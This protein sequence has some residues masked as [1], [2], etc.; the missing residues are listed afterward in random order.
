MN[1]VQA[2]AALACRPR[3]APRTALA[4]ALLLGLGSSQAALQGRD[5]DGIAATFEAYYDTALGITWLADGNYAN[6]QFVASGGIQGHADGLMDWAA[7]KSWADGLDVHGITGWRLPTVRPINGIAFNTLIISNNGIT[8]VGTAKT[9]VGWGTASELGH[10]FY[11]S[12]ANLGLCT[13]ND[14]QP[15]QCNHQIGHTPVQNSGPF[16]NLQWQTYWTEVQSPPASAWTFNFG[17]GAQLASLDRR[18]KVYAIA[19]HPGDVAAVPEP[20]AWALLLLGS[21]AL[22]PALRRRAARPL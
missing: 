5:L 21:L 16:Q 3:A 19:V 22:A 6:T 1:T 11:V 2:H 15:A 9:G 8:D 13:P 7:A 17:N 10:L 12:L 20:G 14:Q 4:A 18:G